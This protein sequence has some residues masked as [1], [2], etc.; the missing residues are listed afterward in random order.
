MVI[1]VVFIQVLK[2]LFFKVSVML[3]FFLEVEGD[4]FLDEI[5]EIVMFLFMQLFD[6][7]VSEIYYY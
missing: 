7:F 2:L 3:E 6:F 1:N 5:D 4:R